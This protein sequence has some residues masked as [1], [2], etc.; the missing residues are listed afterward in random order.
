VTPRSD[1]KIANRTCR[2]KNIQAPVLV[3]P[4][5]KKKEEPLTGGISR[6][7]GR[8][9]KKRKERAERVGNE[10]APAVTILEGNAEEKRTLLSE[11]KE[12]IRGRRKSKESSENPGPRLFIGNEKKKEGR[13]DLRGTGYGAV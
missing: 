9:Q 6:K 7:A 5:G 12:G 11:Q 3:G 8:D 13:K 10:G 1:E 4:K 2:E